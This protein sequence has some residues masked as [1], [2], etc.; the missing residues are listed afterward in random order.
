MI[1]ALDAYAADLKQE[2]EHNAEAWQQARNQGDRTAQDA[3]GDAMRT[4]Y[5]EITEIE[6]ALANGSA[7]VGL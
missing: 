2:F 1:E 3:H 4:L 5:R 6:F 7:L